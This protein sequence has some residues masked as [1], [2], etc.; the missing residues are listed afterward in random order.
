MLCKP[1]HINQIRREGG[2]FGLCWQHKKTRCRICRE[3]SA[4]KLYCVKCEH[5]CDVERWKSAATKLHFAE[6]H[7]FIQVQLRKERLWESKRHVHEALEIIFRA[8]VLTLE[9]IW[10]GIKDPAEKAEPE[11]DAELDKAA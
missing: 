9:S 3:L 4:G 10:G 6:D 11:A 7:E 8:M 1:C 5:G 2:E